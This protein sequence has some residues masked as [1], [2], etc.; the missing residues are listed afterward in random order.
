MPFTVPDKKESFT[1][2][3]ENEIDERTLL[4]V[5]F[6]SLGQLNGIRYLDFNVARFLKRA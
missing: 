3:L 2:I 4:K 6:R 5:G 1:P